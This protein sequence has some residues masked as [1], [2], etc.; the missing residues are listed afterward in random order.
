MP[1][2]RMEELILCE[3]PESWL[4]SDSEKQS[5]PRYSDTDIPLHICPNITVP[6]DTERWSI[7]VK[8]TLMASHNP[9]CFEPVQT[10]TGWTFT[11]PL[12]FPLPTILCS[13]S[14]FGGRLHNASG[15]HLPWCSKLL[16]ARFAELQLCP[17]LSLS[18]LLR[19]MALFN[20]VEP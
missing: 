12:P 10:I 6:K 7:P 3:R 18:E 2:V 1:S 13:I 17:E 20:L 15:C 4:H 16:K 8:V 14:L 11:Y 19:M 5:Q 9:A